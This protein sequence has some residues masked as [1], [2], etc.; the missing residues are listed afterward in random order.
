[1]E[2]LTIKTRFKLTFK[3]NVQIS[4]YSITPIWVCILH[5]NKYIQDTVFIFD[6][7]EREMLFMSF[8]A[9]P[10]CQTKA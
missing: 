2:Y 6:P 7:L 8:P 5:H 10:F 1:M 9:L 3:P 4:S